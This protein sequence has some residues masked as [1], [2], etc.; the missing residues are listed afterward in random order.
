VDVQ[1]C[2]DEI[3][4]LEASASTTRQCLEGTGPLEFELHHVPHV[5]Q[6]GTAVHV[7]VLPVRPGRVVI[8]T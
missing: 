6:H 5:S 4:D 3:G 7:H 2:E 8:K 1:V